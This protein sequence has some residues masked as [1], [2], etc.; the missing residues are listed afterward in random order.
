MTYFLPVIFYQI[1]KNVNLIS[2]SLGFE[3]ESELEV[4]FVYN[5]VII[6]HKSNTIRECLKWI[7]VM[8][9]FLVNM[10]SLYCIHM[11]WQNYSYLI[12]NKVISQHQLLAHLIK[13]Y[14]LSLFKFILL[15]LLAKKSYFLYEAWKGTGPT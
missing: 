1:K 10:T 8:G 7:K 11:V 12:I 4:I 15:T 6:S 2:M 9:V 13:K 5:K 3:I 14:W